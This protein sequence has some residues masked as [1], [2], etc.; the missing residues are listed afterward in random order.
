M[1]RS[2]TLLLTAV[3]AIAVLM[4]A[5]SFAGRAESLLEKIGVT[6]GICV[7]LGDTSCEVALDLARR[8]E[9]LIYVQLPRTAE[10][11]AAQALVDKAGFYGTRIVVEKGR[12]TELHL[13]DNLAD[14]VI[15]L[16]TAPD[17]PEEEALRVLRPQGKAL[18]GDKVLTKPFPEGID[19]WGHPY[20]GPDNNPQSQDRTIQG[21][22]LTQFLAEPRYAPVPQ[23][24]VASAGRVFKAFGHVAFKKREEPYLNKLVAFNGYNGTI[25]WQRDLTPGIMVHRNTLIATP[26]TLYVGDDKS[27]KLID[28]ASGQ[29]KGEIVP[30]LDIA[31]GTFWKWMAVEKGVLYALIGEQEQMD[32]TMRWGLE[33][34]GWPW[35]P[36]SKGFNQPDRVKE[37]GPAYL[38]HPWG[39]GCNVLAIDPRTREV[40]WHYREAE[41]IDSR[42][43]CMK[44]GRIY[45]FRFGAYLT[46]LDANTGAVVWR[47]T[48]ANDPELFTALG[49]YSNRQ[50]ASWNWRTTAYLKCS[51]EALYFASPQV[52]KLVAV[53]TQDG[54]VLWQH[55]YN[56]FQLIIRDDALYGIAG[57]NDEGN[58]SKKFEPLTGAILEEFRTGRRAC[59]RPTAALDAIF[60]RARGG[61]TR[62]DLGSGSPQLVS[63]MRPPCH[64]GV[65]IANGL[66]YW[67]P[68]VCDCQLTLYGI[69]SLG[70][71]RG[72]DFEAQAT[73]KERLETG[74]ATLTDA[75]T[76]VESPADWPTLRASNTRTATSTAT[77]PAQVDLLW[78]TPS[79]RGD[80]CVA[81]TA[82]VVVGDI[83]CIG[84]SDGVVRA[85]SA[86]TGKVLWKAYTGGTIRLPPTIWQGRVFVGSG[87]GWVYAF[88]TRTGQLLWRFRAAPAE[89]KIPV[90]GSLL[91]TWPAASGV[92]VEDGVAY[93]AAGIV[94]YDGTYVYA[95]DAVTGR[96]KWQNDSSGHLDPVARSGVSVQGHLL[97]H[98]RKLYLA[99]GNAVSPAVYDIQDGRCLNDPKSVQRITQNNVLLTQSPRG[100][101]LS[102]LADQVVAFGK[103][104]YAHPQYE[105]YDP[106]VFSRVFL[107]SASGRDIAWV[108]DQ[109]NRQVLCFESINKDALRQRILK[110]RDPLVVDWAGLG[111]KD[112]PLWRYDCADSVAM[113]VCRNAVAVAEK[114]QVAAL[115]LADGRP[116]WSRRVPS[117]PV[118]WGLAVDREG[119]VIVALEDG[120]ILCFGQ[121]TTKAK[122]RVAQIKVY[123]QKGQMAANHR[124]L[125][126]VLGDIEKV[127]A[128][129]ASPV[130]DVVVTPEGFLDGYVST[131]SSVTKADMM[132]YAIDPAT[133]EY[134]LEAS[135]WARR[136]RTWLIYGCTRR[137]KDQ[138][139]NTALIYDRGGSLVGMY[140]KLHLQNH[141]LK[142][143]PGR[144]LDVY[145][146]D[147]GLFGVMICADRRWPETTR[148]LTLRGAR[149]IFNPTYGMHGD[150]NLSMMRTRSY[151]NGIFIAFTHPGQSLITGPA[152]NVVCNNEE[153]ARTY[154]ITEI[155]LSKAP[156]NKGGHLADRR[157]D[158][159]GW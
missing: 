137:E 3:A 6:K 151:E 58:L 81:P 76:P 105:V 70:P 101:E 119:R 35:S 121:H 115:N 98:D 77:I 16:G 24:A 106:S 96:I 136:N 146:S 21:P 91:S 150:L 27:C 139:F 85:L 123:P 10:V 153:E 143:A 67:W 82:P 103:P 111:V 155:D 30:R 46:C 18:L 65:T 22:Y 75:D 43:I 12:T 47:K 59:T 72:F 122:I 102:L 52:G 97:L 73:D 141:D 57:Q 15:V 107:T 51:D 66:L 133:S 147:F 25:L 138:V 156:A 117:R 44:N 56:N 83:I 144:H 41:P 90:Y 134:A 132:S 31:G 126:N 87:D 20:H 64:D 42:A 32:P 5:I 95:L 29:L 92:L 100:W 45:A 53:S 8:S 55:P 49:L 26:T 129:H 71:A 36:I 140:D 149:V 89:R 125:M 157:P 113:A 124:K 2:K 34:H 99:G 23:V 142:Y 110:P 48:L 94:N 159:Y 62:F 50:G 54:R 118:D 116:L 114:S 152:G 145:E 60:Y 1:N 17:V 61:S 128:T 63:P 130:P 28:S 80:A 112:R 120:Q 104:F 93:V 86:S 84:G 69:T 19:D 7:V 33:K 74:N 13:A 88:A 37:S 135:A 148:T 14:A 127:G 78:Q 109:N 39:F 154:V 9:L 68:S 38:A 158:V 131:E 4:P 40:L 108:S 79:G 11:E